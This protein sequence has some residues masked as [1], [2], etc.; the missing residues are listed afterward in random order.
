MKLY[1]GYF[2]ILIRSGTRNKKL[3][4]EVGQW[5]NTQLCRK[6]L[7]DEYHYVLNYQHL[8][9]VGFKFIKLLPKAKYAEILTVD[10]CNLCQ[11]IHKVNAAFHEN[12]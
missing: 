7:G 5:K 3:P 12:P 2:K 4:I 1:N 8:N 6:D 9:E 10:E 11:F